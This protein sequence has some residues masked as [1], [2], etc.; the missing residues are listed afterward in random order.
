MD[1][2]LR[3][4]EGLDPDRL[5]AF[6]YR[7]HGC[8]GRMRYELDDGTC[9]EFRYTDFWGTD[10]SQWVPPFRCKVC[11]DG[12][13]EAADIAAADTWPGGSPDPATEAVEPFPTRGSIVA[14]CHDCAVLCANHHVTP[15]P[16]RLG[17]KRGRC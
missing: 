9:K 7:G 10:E 8:P 17:I 3:D 12:I 1:R 16:E 6:R 2:F 11:P 15:Y 5:T 13:G 4:R 14:R